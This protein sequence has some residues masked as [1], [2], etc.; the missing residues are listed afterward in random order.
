M[1]ILEAGTEIKE[2]QTAG[3]EFMEWA[4]KYW[5]LDKLVKIE[6]PD[7]FAGETCDYD[8]MRNIF[9]KKINAI[10]KDRFGE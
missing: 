3:Q 10:I 8:Y 2:K 5:H 9:I 7:K 1:S 6:N 4:E